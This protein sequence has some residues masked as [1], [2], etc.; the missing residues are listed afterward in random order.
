[1]LGSKQKKSSRNVPQQP[2]NSLEEM[3]FDYNG[4]MLSS[5]PGDA[6]LCYPQRI[7]EIIKNAIFIAQHIDNADEYKSVSITQLSIAQFSRL[8]ILLPN[9]EPRRLEVC[10]DGVGS[11][12]LVDLHNLVYRGHRQHSDDGAI[13]L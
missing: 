12:L 13:D 2:P 5:D 1:M 9:T 6:H 4:K 11:F 8:T 7:D 3:D 10:F